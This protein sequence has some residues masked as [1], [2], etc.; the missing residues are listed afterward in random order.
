[1]AEHVGEEHA[2]LAGHVAEPE[3]Q[4]GPAVAVDVRDPELVA[5]DGDVVALAGAGRRRRDDCAVGGVGLFDVAGL[6]A[7]ARVLE[8]VEDLPRAETGRR[9][10]EVPVHRLLIG[11]VGWT[12]VVELEGRRLGGVDAAV[13]TRRDDV[14]DRPATEIALPVVVGARRDGL[15]DFGAKIRCDQGAYGDRRSGA[16]ERR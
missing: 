8:V 14:V 15:R 11:L 10:D 7:E 2:V 1:M 3:H 6:G 16:A 9:V 12:G 5:N 4:A 13:L